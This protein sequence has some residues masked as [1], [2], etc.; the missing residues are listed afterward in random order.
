MLK[1]AVIA[2]MLLTVALAAAQT[3]PA[4]PDTVSRAEVV[5]AARQALEAASRDLGRWLTLVIIFMLAVV[6]LAAWQVASLARRLSRLEDTRAVWDAR[7]SDVTDE[8]LRVKRKLAEIDGLAGRLETDFAALRPAA[9]AATTGQVAAVQTELAATRERLTRTEEKLEAMADRT[10]AATQTRAVIEELVRTA[11]QARTA[12]EAAA[13]RAEAAA[14][15]LTA[16]EWL[17]NGNVNLTQR[18]YPAAVE[19][20]SHCLESLGTGEADKPDLRFAAL[21]N[22]ALANLR[23]GHLTAVLADSA[24]LGKLTSEKAQGA[25]RAL[26]GVVRLG[27]GAVA[28]ALQ[29]FTEAVKHDAAA[30]AVI[31]RDEDIAAW[32]KAHPGKAA[33]V[34]KYIRTLGKAPR[35]PGVAAAKPRPRRAGPARRA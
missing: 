24:E 7:F 15:R 14:R 2:L 17:R 22:R 28:Q 29:D 34:K 35:K 16:Q 19:A 21:H 13:A 6:A 9:P 32:V 11:S 26:S 10:V 30:A 20:Y 1:R 5:L 25:A 4:G 31:R 12:A 33:P 18:R 27:Q 3:R 23:Q 8:L